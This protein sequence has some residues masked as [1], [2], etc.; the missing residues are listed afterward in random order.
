MAFVGVYGEIAS[1]VPTLE[2]EFCRSLFGDAVVFGFTPEGF[3]ITIENKPSPLIVL[4]PQKIVIKADNEDLLF[5]YVTEIKQEFVKK[6]IIIPTFVAFG[7]NY[8]CQWLLDNS[9]NSEEWMRRHFISDRFNIDYSFV[10][11]LSFRFVI[12]ED[13]MLNFSIEPRVG[14]S[15]GLFANINHHHNKNLKS[16]PMADDLKKYCK[17][18]KEILN[19]YIDKLE[20]R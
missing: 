13:E 16:I 18:S 14:R 19:E 8:E 10:N 1:M 5:K 4:G 20:I 11:K 6:K 2:A 15:D 12:N 17:S 7:I 9:C 3:C